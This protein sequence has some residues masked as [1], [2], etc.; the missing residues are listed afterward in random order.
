M[1]RNKNEPIPKKLLIQEKKNIALWKKNRALHT[2]EK[3][4]GTLETFKKL[5]AEMKNIIE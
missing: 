2:K 1:Q 4:N 3:L 5:V